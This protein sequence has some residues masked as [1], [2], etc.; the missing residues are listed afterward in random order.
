MGD[1]EYDESSGPELQIQ[2]MRIWYPYHLYFSLA[3]QKEFKG[4]L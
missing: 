2:I 4:I 1:T 3:L